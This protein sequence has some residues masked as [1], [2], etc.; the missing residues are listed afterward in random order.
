MILKKENF[1][2]LN[3]SELDEAIY[4]IF[5]I[6]RAVQLFE[7]KELVMP[8]IKAW[9]DVYENFFLKSNFSEGDEVF[10][11]EEDEGNFCFGQ[12]W[13]FI[14]D[15]DAMW[16]IYSHDKQSVRI[17]TTLRKLLNC[18]NSSC[19]M[20]VGLNY[21]FDASVYIGKVEYRA[22]EQIEE[23]AS[24]QKVCKNNIQKSVVESLC[25]KRDSF[26]HEEE[27]RILYFTDDSDS[28]IIKKT[29]NHLIGFQINP[30]ELIDEIAFDPRAEQSFYN[31]YKNHLAT[32]FSFPKSR[33]VKSNLYDF[34]PLTFIIN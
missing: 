3:E 31:A 2:N 30:M 32:E 19:S 17:K 11:I 24:N 33:I 26:K 34:T 16:R 15:S 8:T 13:S 9:E 29:P 18:L 21:V 1:I 22:I 7:N 20:Q 23:W 4:R 28:K 14:E 12:C 5:P 25:V 10:S 6:E 27:A